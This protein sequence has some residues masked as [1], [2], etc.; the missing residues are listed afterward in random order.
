MTR[1]AWM[2]L[3]VP[4][5]AFPCWSWA[6]QAKIPAHPSELVFPPLDYD[7]PKPADYRHELPEGAVAY[8]VED[9]QLPLINVSVTIRTGGYLVSD[10]HLGLAS[11]TGEQMRAGGTESISARDFDEQAAFL[12]TQISSGIGA[13]SGSAGMNCL[14]QNL[15]ASLDLLFDMLKSPGF[16]PDRL[17]LAVSRRLQAMERRNDRTDAIQSREFTRLLRGANHFSAKEPTKATV[18]SLT[19]DQ[20]MEFHRRYY[21]PSS[22]I[23]AVSGDFDTQQ[24]LERIGEALSSGWPGP[25]PEVPKVPAPRHSPAPGVY[26]VNKPD[27]NQGRVA[28]G[29]VGIERDN[30][31]HIAVGIMNQILGGGGFTSRIMSRVRSD[32]GLAYSAGSSFQPGVYY[33]GTFQAGFQSKS[34]SCAEAATIVLEEVRRIREGKVSADELETAKNYSAE[35]FPRFFATAGQVAG[36]FA[37]DEYTGREKG[38][39]QKYRQ[40][41]AAV[42]PDD[43]LRVAEQYIDPDKLVILAVGNVSDMLAGNPDK[44]Q[45]QFKKLAREGQIHHIQLPDPLTMEYPPPKA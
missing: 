15:E 34:A 14:K 10:P 4:A 6:Q 19:R 11:L 9:R 43:V 21:H 1:R 16:D 35:I 18:E 40:R 23:F 44:P 5:A 32:E 17:Q 45:F 8:L 3:A 12:A 26:M 13:T 31:D 41:I 27:V 29:H 2:K 38:Y 30:P 25:K 39:W 7:P 33:P 22:M 42:T 37:S 24:M 20:L 28:M 36:T